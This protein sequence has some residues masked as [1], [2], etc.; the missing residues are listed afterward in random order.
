MT[1]HPGE[2]VAKKYS[3]R[4]IYKYRF[5]DRLIAKLLW[6][7][8]CFRNNTQKHAWNKNDQYMVHFKEDFILL[9]ITYLLTKGYDHGL[10][11]VTAS[12]PS[13]KLLH[14]Q[15]WTRRVWCMKVQRHYLK[16]GPTGLKLGKSSLP[17]G[18]LSAKKKNIRRISKLDGRFN[19]MKKKI[20]AK[21][22]RKIFLEL[23]SFFNRCQNF[24]QKMV[25]CFKTQQEFFLL[26]RQKST[27][28]KFLKNLEP[29]NLLKLKSKPSRFES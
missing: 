4:R 26:L 16:H 23:A 28:N 12:S 25:S 5:C 10:A 29:L 21:K 1:L 6:T 15:L 14:W 19:K 20:R 22:C 7:N 24:W 11:E 9:V 3:L 2:Q 13:L 17:K 27:N 18:P 8:Q